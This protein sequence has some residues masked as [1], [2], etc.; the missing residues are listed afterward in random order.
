[1]NELVIAEH[2]LK[3]G[4]SEEDIVYAWENFVRKRYRGAPREGEVIAVGYDKQG[5]FIEM[6]GLERGDDIIIYHAMQP[7]TT[8][9]LIELDLV[10]R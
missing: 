4:L 3:H 9:A 1:M 10:R 7:P 6:V 5:R 2:A 8:N